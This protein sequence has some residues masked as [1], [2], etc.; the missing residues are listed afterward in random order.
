MFTM[1]VSQMYSLLRVLGQL[2]E[3]TPDTTTS[4]GQKRK[5]NPVSFD[6]A[7]MEEA[8]RPQEK[9]SKPPYKKT[10]YHRVIK[11]TGRS[12][13]ATSDGQVY[14]SMEEA[15]AA[16]A[17][18]WRG[19]K[20]QFDE[21][22]DAPFPGTATSSFQGFATLGYGSGCVTVMVEDVHPMD[23]PK[24][25]VVQE[26]QRLHVSCAGMS[27]ADMRT[28]YHDL[29]N[30]RLGARR[31]EE[32]ERVKRADQEAANFTCEVCGAPG[33][34]KKRSAVLLKFELPDGKVLHY[35]EKCGKDDAIFV[36]STEARKFMGPTLFQRYDHTP[37]LPVA[38]GGWGSYGQAR[39]YRV[40]DMNKL[41]VANGKA[42]KSYP[43]KAPRAPRGM[44]VFS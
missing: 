18:T 44:W 17:G 22:T 38:L 4:V 24:A 14:K 8:A 43:K 41:L 31:E 39:F 29:L 16:A 13:K 30:P 10:G 7:G 33:S 6:A 19:M 2:E 1:Y 3:E 25:V 23:M 15:N 21:F 5:V 9:K 40:E 32:E 12:G 28:K 27:L 26:L 20:W 36:S 42:T 37:E 34:V 11:M 35:H